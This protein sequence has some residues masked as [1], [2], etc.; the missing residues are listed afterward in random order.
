MENT[1][2]L[3]ELRNAL[4]RSLSA[5][6]RA[7]PDALI[8]EEAQNW[9]VFGGDEAFQNLALLQSTSESSDS[10]WINKLKETS[11]EHTLIVCG[12]STSEEALSKLNYTRD[13]EFA[14]M[15]VHF[16]SLADKLQ[17]S[18]KVKTSTK[19]DEH[20]TNALIVEAQDFPRNAKLAITA[21]NGHQSASISSFHVEENGEMVSQV[22]IS[23]VGEY[24]GFWA[25]SSAKKQKSSG[26]ESTLIQHALKQAQSMG[27]K[28]AIALISNK[29]PNVFIESG[30]KQLEI[31]QL[32]S[33]SDSYARIPGFGPNLLRS[34]LRLEHGEICASLIEEGSNKI[35]EFSGKTWFCSPHEK[36]MGF[37]LSQSEHYK[38]V[39]SHAH[40]VLASR[41]VNVLVLAGPASIFAERVVSDLNQYYPKLPT[42]EALEAP[43]ESQKGAY[44]GHKSG[45]ATIAGVYPAMVYDLTNENDSVLVSNEEPD[46]HIRRA[47]RSDRRELGIVL[48]AAFEMHSKDPNN[49]TTYANGAGHANPNIY[50]WIYEVDG[51]KENSKEIGATVT[52]VVRNKIAHV[53]AV[54]THPKHQ[55]KGLSSKLMK[56]AVRSARN[57]AGARIGFLMATAAGTPVYKRLGWHTIEDWPELFLFAVGST[58]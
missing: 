7:I 10:Q 21:A 4:G 56:H 15:G 28:Q 57:D 16:D 23:V 40:R 20:P 58:E 18:D 11:K 9:L 36:D 39:H 30:W 13:G 22:I 25:L 50:T 17:L 46:K 6:F 43:Q 29:G 38:D 8:V 51:E 44:T 37:A 24:V 48:D 41:R 32:F 34:H 47:E 53:W 54:A 2:P 35:I 33:T 49:P 12:D 45:V 55:R 42:N 14:L 27:A 31:V 1:S 19:Q 26:V 52:V 3:P 5:I